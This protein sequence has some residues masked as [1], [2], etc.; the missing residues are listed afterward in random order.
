MGDLKWTLDSIQSKLTELDDSISWTWKLLNPQLQ[1]KIN[2]LIAESNNLLKIDIQNSLGNS[3]IDDI[4]KKLEEVQKVLDD[5]SNID[6][7]ENWE[8][9]WKA[10][11]ILLNKVLQLHYEISFLKQKILENGWNEAQDANMNNS[12][13]NKNELNSDNQGVEFD[14]DQNKVDLFKKK[15]V[16]CDPENMLVA[17]ALN[18]VKIEYYH[19]IIA[20]DWNLC[21]VK[22]RITKSPDERFNNKEMTCLLDNSKDFDTATQ[23]VISSFTL[24]NKLWNCR[25]ELY[26]LMVSL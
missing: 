24:E 21:I 26:D 20:P 5:D 17:F 9:V 14:F 12:L 13:L 19:E 1:E 7:G 6:F 22:S 4:N 11:R 25:W 18:W 15:F 23:E 16:N 3:K 2:A 8:Q 10:V